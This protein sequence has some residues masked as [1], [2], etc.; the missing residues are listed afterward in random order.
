M[1]FAVTAG[2]SNDSPLETVEIASARD[3]RRDD[4]LLVGVRREHDDFRRRVFG[5]D[6]AA[7]LDAGAVAEAHV[8]DD[9][10]RLRARR[11]RNGA[12]HRMRFGHDAHVRAAVE[13]RAQALAHD[14]VIVDDHHSNLVR[15]GRMLLRAAPRP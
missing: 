9:D 14:L 11:L 15:H 4:G 10:V 8:H 13:E 2:S 5:P 7:R 3:D 1:T 6:L 12:L